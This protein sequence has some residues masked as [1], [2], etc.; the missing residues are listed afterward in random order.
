MQPQ[1]RGGGRRGRGP[2]AQATTL[3]LRHSPAQPWPSGRSA[4]RRRRQRRRRR[5]RGRRR[6]RGERPPLPPRG[7]GWEGEAGA[8]AQGSARFPTAHATLGTGAS[9]PPGPGWG[10]V[11]PAL[12]PPPGPRVPPPALSEVLKL[13]P[14]RPLGLAPPRP[15][16]YTVSSVRLPVPQSLPLPCPCESAS[17]RG[18]SAQV[19]DN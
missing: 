9:A 17:W 16:S 15:E 4:A 6:G 18:P 7:S 11:S 1:E 10:V 14:P 13:R 5:W 8:P 12:A 3:S 19:S 2:P